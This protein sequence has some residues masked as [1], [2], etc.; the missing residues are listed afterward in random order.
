MTEGSLVPGTPGYLA[1]EVAGGTDPTTASDVFSLGALLF[2][3]VEGSTPFGEAE[4]PPVLVRRAVAAEIRPA[5]HAGALAPVLSAL[6]SK[7]PAARPDAARARELLD[8][9]ASGATTAEV[10]R[11]LDHRPGNRKPVLLALAAVVV[12]AAAATTFALLNREGAPRRVVMGDPRTADPCA[13]TDAGALARFGRVTLETDYGAFE[14][15]DVMVQIPGGA[16][17]DVR[18]ELGAPL[19]PDTPDSGPSEVLGGLRVI[20]RPLEEEA[21]L[22]EIVL[23]DQYRV[24]VEAE[25]EEGNGPVDYCAISE[26][27]TETAVDR[28]AGGEVPRRAR[29]FDADSLAHLKACELI[30]D[31]TLARIPGALPEHADTEFADWACDWDDSAAEVNVQLK[32][33]RNQPLSDRHG[34]ATEVN[35]H[36]VRLDPEDEGAGSCVARVVRRDYRD[37][38]GRPLVELVHLAL[39]GDQQVDRLCATTSAM[40]ASIAGKLPG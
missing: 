36:E 35:G 25:R 32:F 24:Y 2:R 8:L 38:D 1:P 11:A 31:A 10:D 13:L 14:R 19:A 12:V 29:P 7:D 30:D 37:R 5:P 26:M 20:R 4:N 33:D 23:A 39:D 21:C 18:L 9:V 40:A 22:R 16:R 27:A 17:I 6:L 3:A 34:T 28:L 15:C